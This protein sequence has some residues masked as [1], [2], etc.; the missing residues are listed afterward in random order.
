MAGN[1]E[2]HQNFVD[3]IC[4]SDNHAEYLFSQ[5]TRC[6]PTHEQIIRF[7]DYVWPDAGW[8]ANNPNA[9]QAAMDTGVLQEA[10]R[11]D[12]FWLTIWFDS[13]MTEEALHL[14]RV[15]VSREEPWSLRDMRD[16][17]TRLVDAGVIPDYLRRALEAGIQ[18][19]DIIA[20]GWS[21]RTPV[22][23]LVRA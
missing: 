13:G 22:E 1:V 11:L 14:V 20:A 15:Y 3:A 19:H 7:Y 5:L 17:L 12:D 23:Y 6:Q 10:P 21:K 18:D 9:V 16:P 8:R 2:W 4:V